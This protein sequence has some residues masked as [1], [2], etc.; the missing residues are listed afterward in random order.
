MK[1]ITSSL[2]FKVISLV[3]INSF[4]LL[5]IAW[6]G[7]TELSVINPT[8]MLSPSVQISQQVL[9]DSFNELYE[10][11]HLN[12]VFDMNKIKEM[13]LPKQ[14]FEQKESKWARGWRKVKDWASE[15][16]KLMAQ[17]YKSDKKDDDSDFIL[18]LKSVLLPAFLTTAIIALNFKLG[19]AG[20][21]TEVVS[22][23][24]KYG[25]ALVGI[26]VGLVG[27]YKLIRHVFFS[28]KKAT[29][30]KTTE[31][32]I[33][34]YTGWGGKTLEEELEKRGLKG[35]DVEFLKKEKANVNWSGTSSSNYEEADTIY[36]KVIK[37]VIPLLIISAFLTLTPDFVWAGDESFEHMIWR[38]KHFYIRDF[39]YW[40]KT[41]Y[42]AT[43]AYGLGG[44]LF[45]GYLN[46]LFFISKEKF[47]KKT[48]FTITSTFA[49]AM[50]S[51]SIYLSV[52][53]NQAYPGVAFLVWGY[54]VGAIII[55]YNP[56][57]DKV[58]SIMY[59]SGDQYFA[60][61]TQYDS[62]TIVDEPF[63]EH[64]ISGKRI[65]EEQAKAAISGQDKKTD[66]KGVAVETMDMIVTTKG[67]SVETMDMIVTTKGTVV[68]TMD[69]V[70]QYVPE[71][72]S[73]ELLLNAKSS[74]FND[75]NAD[76][77][78]LCGN[79][80]IGTFK[81]TLR[82]YKAG[83]VEKILLTGG[84]GRLTYPL[85]VAAK[86]A[87]INVEINDQ[88]FITPNHDLE[89]LLLPGTTEYVDLKALS[90][91]KDRTEFKNIVKRSE[92]EI[93]NQIM[94]D[95]AVQMGIEVDEKD[96]YIEKDSTNT[97]EN[98]KFAISHI[99]QIKRDLSKNKLVVAY[100]QTPHQQFRTKASFNRFKREWNDIGV[101]GISYTID[102]DTSILTQDQLIEKTAS[103]L[104][105][106]LIYAAKGDIAPVYKDK[107]GL[108]SIPDTYWS[109]LIDLMKNHHDQTKLKEMLLA[110][111]VSE[112][113]E[114]ND[115]NDRLKD[116]G[117]NISNNAGQFIKWVYSYDF[118]QIID[119]IMCRKDNSLKEK[120]Y[121][122]RSIRSHYAWGGEVMIDI[123]IFKDVLGSDSESLGALSG[124]QLSRKDMVIAL[125][126]IA[127]DKS[128][129]ISNNTR[130]YLIIKARQVASFTKDQK[131]R[132]A[133]LELINYR[134][135]NGLDGLR[136]YSSDRLS[137]IGLDFVLQSI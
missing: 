108:E 117:V 115:L 18:G 74:T 26:G 41:H 129:K 86:E 107:E 27:L 116:S 59:E 96:I 5:D 43:T 134:L 70:T 91:Q 51:L 76:V 104:W 67:T 87:K 28:V 106:V 92:S 64:T 90:D 20:D 110:L 22:W 16:V 50:Y 68:E 25:G 54:I 52:L 57:S 44:V 15:T 120:I 102:W 24:E 29:T 33:S 12:T 126:G 99:E 72:D 137:K 121:G 84:Y 95:L 77:L 23:M 36:Y 131:E 42:I 2:F 73:L 100:M 127:L 111:S 83:K 55:F 58:M 48:V 101:R 118:N 13:S 119:D 14:M 69:R 105:R 78:L 8:E 80:D 45:L 85:L 46:Y 56:S 135:K 62:A 34:V 124:K 81:E 113:K 97:P 47:S 89:N 38:F 132:V 63:T 19:W 49:M 98:F 4:L 93:I 123:D 82:L 9:S 122:D 35:A 32:I 31:T 6:A 40:A 109:K 114:D 103:E 21:G 125:F 1:K 71:Q 10:L 60:G 130:E 53:M 88:A 133:L 30:Q 94:S 136:K 17:S 11:Q 128:K 65:T 39:L 112:Y 61:G 3:L 37:S 66:T 79:D 7:G 75:L